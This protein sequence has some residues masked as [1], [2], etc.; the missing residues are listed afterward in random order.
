[1]RKLYIAMALLISGSVVIAQK[2]DPAA[3]Q[4]LLQGFSGYLFFTI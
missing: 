2:N 1:M 4:V 3:K